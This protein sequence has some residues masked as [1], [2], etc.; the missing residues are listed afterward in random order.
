MARMPQVPQTDRGNRPGGQVGRAVLPSENGAEAFAS[1]ANAVEG[2]GQNTAKLDDARQQGLNDALAAKQKIVDHVTAARSAG[3]FEENLSSL[4][5]Q[6]QKDYIDTPDKAPAAYLEAARGAANDAVKAAPNSAVGL[7]LS[8]KTASSINSGMVGMHTWAQGRMTQKA[9]SDLTVMD[10]QVVN[11]AAAQ[12]DLKGL[13]NYLLIKKA[14]L[15]QAYKGI[16]GDPEAEWQKTASAATKNWFVS[17]G[18]LDPVAGLKA[19]DEAKGPGIDNLNAEQRDSVRK[20][21]QQSLVGFGKEQ[22]FK[23]VSANVKD[24]QNLYDAH[25]DGS[26]DAKT[27]DSVQNANALEQASTKIDP[28]LTPEQRDANLGQLQ[29]TSK[30][31]DALA[32]IHREGLRYDGT[33]DPDTLSKLLVDRKDLF[34]TPEG[35]NGDDLMRVADFQHR[36][37]AAA[38][39]KKLS[40]GS[41]QTMFNSV[42]LD[43]P[44]AL[45]AESE[46]TGPGA[47]SFWHAQTPRQAGNDAMNKSP[48]FMHLDGEA[49][50]RARIMYMGMLNDAVKSGGDTST[51]SVTAMAINAVKL[52][53]AK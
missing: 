10:N 15:G 8:E 25:L 47:W 14:A 26:L 3:D 22:A 30:A 21:L 52:A 19:L 48:D 31:I 28:K 9:K 27:L 46:N 13:S 24:I 4:S 1:G 42:A 17:R 18:D 23:V 29:Q 39:D 43:M 7:A 11:G 53:G 5:T 49:Q 34:K 12:P 41:F 50:S 6:M 2:L 20:S 35:E 37:L 45:A 33:D 38:A 44:K 40:P 32:K 36:L 16:H 51:K